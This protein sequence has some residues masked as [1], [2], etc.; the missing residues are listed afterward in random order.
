MEIASLIVS[1]IALLGCFVGYI[2]HEAYAD[3]VVVKS[4]L[5]PRSAIARV[6]CI[7]RD[8]KK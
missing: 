8:Q 2:L 6:F 1:I 4:L 5:V 3:L 7:G